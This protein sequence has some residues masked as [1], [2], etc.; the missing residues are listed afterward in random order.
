MQARMAYCE[1]PTRM[2][3]IENA[4]KRDKNEQI[5][6]KKK[7]PTIPNI[8]DDVE[9]VRLPHTTER[10][11]HCGSVVVSQKIKH[12]LRI[13]K[14]YF[15]LFVRWQRKTYTHSK[16]RTWMFPVTIFIITANWE[17][18]TYPLIVEWISKLWSIRIMESYS[19]IERTILIRKITWLNLKNL[20]SQRIK[21]TAS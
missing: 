5:I 11:S 12:T 15:H 18:P 20:L 3:K 1:K 8:G 10:Q 14:S 16:I 6:N 2:A 17:Q 21:K 9:H 19:V 4:E 7:I 13:Q